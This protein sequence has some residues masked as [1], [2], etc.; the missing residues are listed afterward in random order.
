MAS[1][2][3]ATE[4]AQ[5]ST[6]KSLIAISQSVPGKTLNSDQTAV[7]STYANSVDSNCNGG[8]EEYRSKLISISYT[9]SP[10]AQPSPCSL[11]NIGS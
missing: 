2:G 6:R 7:S 8:K 10:D 4:F 3:P 9:Q 11:E 5:E 1:T